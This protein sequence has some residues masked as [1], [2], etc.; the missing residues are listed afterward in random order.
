MQR[1]WLSPLRWFGLTLA[2]A[3]S[4]GRP[5][6]A[7]APSPTPY[8]STP[9]ASSRAVPA[10][11][12]IEAPRYR[13]AVIPFWSDTGGTA[14]W[15]A[16]ELHDA[17]AE[18]AVAVGSAVPGVA[19][20]KALRARLQLGDP[21]VGALLGARGADVAVW[22]ERDVLKGQTV[23][24]VVMATPTTSE[25][26]LYPI[27]AGVPASFWAALGDTLTRGVMAEASRYDF[28]TAQTR[29]VDSIRPFVA[30]VR[31]LVGS[32]PFR[33]MGRS[34][35]VDSLW[36]WKNR[37]QVLMSYGDALRTLGEQAGERE[38]L[39]QSI[40][41]YRELLARYLSRESEPYEWGRVEDSLGNALMRLGVRDE[42]PERWVQA[43][44][45]YH[46]A[47][48]VSPREEQS[49][50]WA[51]TQNNLS[52]S[53]QKLG[54][55]ES[56]LGRLLDAVRVARGAAAA[57]DKESERSDWTMTQMTLGN[58]LLGV[59]EREQGTVR[60]LQAI[61]AYRA[62]LQGYTR[63]QAP[64][65]WAGLQKNL[66]NALAALGE[67]ESSTPRLLES[68][69]AD[70]AALEVFTR[71]RLPVHWAIT[72]GSL[73]GT[74][75]SLG[76]RTSGTRWLSEAVVACRAALEAYTR[77]DASDA[78]DAA[79]AHLA[80]ALAALRARSTRTGPVRA[81]ERPAPED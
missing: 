60:L 39:V 8:T 62:A 57:L 67:R 63:E 20:A 26:G 16:M 5:P 65:G 4:G 34:R 1:R 32:P 56:D 44:G 78:H 25:I 59:G 18:L 11:A 71:D 28:D 40:D 55:S 12:P 23:L 64:L 81:P 37:R 42:Q 15:L 7:Q 46:E 47:L 35:P 10:P 9:G 49:Q 48:R 76:E 70:R 17:C 58:A 30:R 80:R 38:A 41:V 33:A 79:E 45:A 73:C 21:S 14:A 61:A 3:C 36:S 19:D 74:L 43:L 29:V 68:V 66:A 31:R 53:L 51:A 2:W 13:V 6:C 77:D 54:E 72:E 69:A 52:I 27:R 22:V 24:R 75:T 50:R